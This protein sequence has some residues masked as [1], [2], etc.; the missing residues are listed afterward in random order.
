MS[1]KRSKDQ[2]I[3]ERYIDEGDGWVRC[4]ECGVK[5]HA[6]EDDSDFW[7]H[8]VRAHREHKSK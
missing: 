3:A 2:I 8:E 7:L 5:V 4:R 6:G 1:K